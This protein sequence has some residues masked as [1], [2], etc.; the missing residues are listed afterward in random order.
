MLVP[1][2]VLCKAGLGQDEKTFTPGPAMSTFPPSENDAIFKAVSSA[3]T[4]KMVGEFAGAL[5]ALTMA[6]R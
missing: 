4:D 6:G 2:M 3:A 1:P 5:A